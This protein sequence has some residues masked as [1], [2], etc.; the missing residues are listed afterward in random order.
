MDI[1][2]VFLLIAIVII[3]MMPPNEYFTEKFVVFNDQQVYVETCKKLIEEKTNVT[4][5]LISEECD[6]N[7][8]QDV[9]M[10]NRDIINKK[11]K[12]KNIIDKIIMLNNE[13]PSWCG[14]VE[15]LDQSGIIMPLMNN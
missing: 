6:I 5:L 8:K 9:N 4:N 10:S 12:C 1:S 2:F 15:Q 13:Q 14:R 7:T 11:I 3:Y